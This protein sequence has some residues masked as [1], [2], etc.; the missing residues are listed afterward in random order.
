[1]T[2]KAKIYSDDTITS[3]LGILLKNKRISE[4][5]SLNDVVSMTLF[6]KSTIIKIEKG[7]I[8]NIHYY[9]A[10]GQALRI[11]ILN[12]SIKIVLKPLYELSEDRKKRQFLTIKVK[13]L[14]MENFFATPKS[15]TDVIDKI[16]ELNNYK[17]TKELSTNI[18][19]VLLNLVEDNLLAKDKKGKNN[20]YVNNDS[21]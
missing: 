1:M 9:I 17:K 14:F 12:D 20:L 8:T 5:L 18:S 10:V 16:I 19:R 11:S 2:N 7:Q 15:T 6:S 13:K 4:G 3:N 21:Y